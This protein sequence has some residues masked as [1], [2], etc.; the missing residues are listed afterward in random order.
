MQRNGQVEKAIEKWRSVAN[1]AEGTD[2][3]RAFQ[4]W[5]S[6]AYLLPKG[7]DRLAAYDKAM[8]L[9]PNYTRSPRN[10]PMSEYSERFHEDIVVNAVLR[11]FNSSKFERFSTVQEHSVGSGS[12]GRVDVALLDRNGRLA[13]I[14]E[15][16]RIGYVGKEWLAQLTEYCRRGDV[17]FGLF[18]SDTAPS[19]WTFLRILGDEITEIN[20]SQFEEELV[21]S[22]SI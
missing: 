13:A 11:Y 4:A 17:Q 21:E 16:K 6:I 5:L 12:Y 10:Q 1:I 2:D 15:C 14:A 7:D 18:A 9:D 19:K 22:G 20:R 8:D 3:D